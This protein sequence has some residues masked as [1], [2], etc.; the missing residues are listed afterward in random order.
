MEPI[1]SENISLTRRGFVKASIAGS[2][3]LALS[4]NL[5]G[6]ATTSKSISPDGAWKADAWLEIKPDNTIVFT[7]D[8]VEMGQGTYTGLTT[9]IAE[10]LDVAPEAINV[11]FAPAEKAYRNPSY[12]IQLTGGSSSL[13]SAWK[14]LRNAGASARTML[15]SA[16]ADT[17]QVS[18]DTLST[19]NGEVMHAASNKRLTYGS[20]AR[21]AAQKKPAESPS[22]KTPSE[23][24]YIG[25]Q[26]QRLDSLTKVTGQ[27]TF[28]IDA[29]IDTAL[30]A[31]VVRPPSI[32][33]ELDAHNG[34]ELLSKGLAEAIVQISSGLAVVA[35][36]YWHARQV[37]Q[38][39][40]VKWR[41]NSA[42]PSD[43][44]VFNLYE[45]T[46]NTDAGNVVR[47]EGDVTTQWS[48]AAALLEVEYRLPFL[49]HATMEPMN[50]TAHI[51]E[52]RADIWTSTQGPDVAQVAVAKVTDLEIEDV[53]V[54][55]QFIGGGF[56]RRLTQDFVAEAAEISA[57]VGLPIKLTWS[58]EDDMRNDFYRPASL[59]KL[60]GAV[61]EKGNVL[62]WKHH[63]VG[64]ALMDW[65]VWD[66]APAKLSWA[67]KYMYSMLGSIGLMAQGTPMAP[68]DTSG[69]EGAD[70]LDYQ[71]RNQQV[72]YSKAD[73]G[74][75]VSYWRAVGH[76]YNGYVTESFFDEMA[77]A[78]KKDPVAMRLELLSE[79]PRMRKV[80][81]TLADKGNWGRV[82]P[83]GVFQGFA[84]HKS[85][86]SFVAQIVELS[87]RSDQ[88]KI[89]KVICVVDCGTVVNP[90]I[91][92]MQME[93]GIVFGLTAALYGEINFDEGAPRQSNFHDYQMLR[94]N[95]MPVIE[96]HIIASDEK[97]TGVGEPGLPPLA[98]AVANALYKATGKRFRSMPFRLNA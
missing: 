7:L 12:G 2:G 69:Y 64:P 39:L 5:A 81:E 49:A 66:V 73:A 67:P 62:A 51:Q 60:K 93:S 47:E 78:A 41:D 88:I 4:L 44:L 3:G 77:E 54:H 21:L 52:N 72:T 38:K 43:A 95:E 14:P 15:I 68:A 83:N 59:H 55:N 57:K 29:G 82:T 91:V 13:S 37:E 8:R 48:D 85:F 10:E 45:E 97:P 98:P 30:A 74:I 75:P 46:A 23:F 25:K 65:Y 79:S 22:L 84:A 32:G 61:D 86:G 9:L 89:E 92:T 19:A 87:I 58:R 31:I 28:G 80:I 42:A 96:T 76:S 71:F 53:Y 33:A 11:I 20:L 1:H 17:L 36:S 90:D 40:Q 56:G 27:A 6:C 94:M 50:C 18:P 70:D 63:I 24:K 16:A 35:K 26:T 34:E